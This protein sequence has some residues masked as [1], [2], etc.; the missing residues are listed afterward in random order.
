MKIGTVVKLE[1]KTQH[2]RER[3][4]RYGPLSQI[5]GFQEKPLRY[6]VYSLTKHDHGWIT[7]G[8]EDKH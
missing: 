7:I 1:G 5:L 2:G 3:I 8:I 4:T 6:K